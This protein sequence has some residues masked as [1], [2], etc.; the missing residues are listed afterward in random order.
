MEKE[1]DINSVNNT[2]AHGWVGGI[3]IVQTF[4]NLNNIQHGQPSNTF[5]QLSVLMLCVNL[6]RGAV[7]WE[8]QLRQ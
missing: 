7:L 2:E 5:F 1:W 4:H 6:P 3:I 8:P